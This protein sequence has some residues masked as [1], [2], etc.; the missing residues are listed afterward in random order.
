MRGDT[1]IHRGSYSA[2]VGEEAEELD[3]HHLLQRSSS[4]LKTS[5]LRI[6]RDAFVLR[7]SGEGNRPSSRSLTRALPCCPHI[8]SAGSSFSTLQSEKSH[9]DLRKNL[10]LSPLQPEC[11]RGPSWSQQMV[12]L[13]ESGSA[14]G[15]LLIF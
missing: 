6:F 7:C 15:F 9:Q 4:S 1:R 3:E 5:R 11:L 13:T 12:V 14:G 10:H 8:L 2:Q